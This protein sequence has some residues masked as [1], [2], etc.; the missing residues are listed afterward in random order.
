MRAPTYWDLGAYTLLLTYCVILGKF[1]F[2]PFWAFTFF[3]YKLGRQPM[4]NE[5]TQPSLS[6]D[7]RGQQEPGFTDLASLSDL[8]GFL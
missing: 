1:L 5:D 2:H 6:E 7:G 4:W 3:R 8:Q